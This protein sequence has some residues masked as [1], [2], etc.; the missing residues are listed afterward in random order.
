VAVLALGGGAAYADSGQDG[1][2]VNTKCPPV[3]GSGEVGVR[4]GGVGIVRPLHG[5]FVVATGKGT[6]TQLMQA[7]KVT[8]LTNASITVVSSDD[9][10]KKY[11]V[12]KSTI[13]GHGKKSLKDLATGDKVMVLARVSGNTATAI[14][15]GD[16]D[17]VRPAPGG[18]DRPLP[19]LPGPGDVCIVPRAS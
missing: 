7:G 17:T 13:V 14:F 3:V 1:P 9:Y 18:P 15:I 8:A 2:T 4:P 16:Q 10:T 11:K 6:E 19:P 12:D 5:E